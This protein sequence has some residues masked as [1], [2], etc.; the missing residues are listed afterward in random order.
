VLNP[1]LGMA[2]V[3][4]LLGGL[5]AGLRVWQR[6]AAP[7]P[8]LIRK[9][10][11][12]G[13]GLVTLSFPWVFDAAWPVLLLT[14]GSVAAL[15]LLRLTPLGNVL[16]AVNRPSFGEAYFPVAVA[17]LFA[18]FL[19]NDRDQPDH[20]L[21]LYLVPILL[22]TLADAAAALIGVAYGRHRFATSEGEKSA[23]GSTAFFTCA[24]FCVH[25]PVLLLT[26]NGRPETLLIAVLMAWL[27]TIFEAVAWRGLDNLALPLVS[28]LLLSAY[29][30]MTVT[31]LLIRV[32]VTVL[33]MAFLAVYRGR[34]TLIGSAVLGAYLV[35]YVC[36]A[37]GGWR[38]LL[39]PLALFLTYTRFSA[40][41]ALNPQRS[42]NIYAVVAAAAA[43]IAW[44]FLAQQFG[45]PDFLLPYTIAFGGH[46]AIAGIARLRCDSPQIPPKRLIPASIGVAWLVQ[47][48]L[49]LVAMGF[50]TAAV[51][52]TT[53]GLAGIAFVALTFCAIQPGL[54][55]CPTD[56]PRWLRQAAASALGSLVG[57]IPLLLWG[58]S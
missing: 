9:L 16:S 23:E 15:L 20:R 5:T 17:L 7:H 38:W 58:P 46:L 11:H 53:F 37:V 8:E 24:F 43:G 6:R 56:T 14:V 48:A 25:V 26:T 40:K 19:H 22:L 28:Y 41:E 10:L 2:S 3:L 54:D 27:A 31:L 47:F 57:L 39:A 1:W 42:H 52:G 33:L 35:G 34:T 12:V 55:D 13:M 29:L 51:V 30:D 45:R 36:W 18:Q 4:A 44:L 32:G 49:Y 50:T 21:V